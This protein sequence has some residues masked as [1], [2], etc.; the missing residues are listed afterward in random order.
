MNFGKPDDSEM[1][2]QE[3]QTTH[4]DSY[5]WVDLKTILGLMVYYRPMTKTSLILILTTNV[6]PV[7]LKMEAV[8]V[9]AT[10]VVAAT[11]LTRGYLRR[12]EF[13]Q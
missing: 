7:H 4:K 10:T 9:Q 11:T 5:Q 8:Q 6:L 12:H 1:A 3:F 13:D 2:P